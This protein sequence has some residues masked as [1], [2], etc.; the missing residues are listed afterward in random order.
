[1]TLAITIN[2]ISCY[3]PT[4]NYYCSYYYYY[5]YYNFSVI[6]ICSNSIIIITIIIVI[7]NHIMIISRRPSPSRSAPGARPR[8]RS[9]RSRP[10]YYIL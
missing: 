10:I 8:S 3:Y 4:I 9:S 7:I 1:M 6:I 2:T 5:Y